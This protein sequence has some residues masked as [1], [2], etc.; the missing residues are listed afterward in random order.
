MVRGDEAGGEVM[1]ET[2]DIGRSACSGERGILGDTPYSWK[3]KTLHHGQLLGRLC[4]F[5]DSGI[6]HCV[7]SRY[8]DAIAMENDKASE[9]VPKIVPFSHS[10][11]FRVLCVG[12]PGR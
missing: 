2:S 5:S 3:L 4:L 1:D 10:D 6:R 8:I 7:I 12:D 11:S 9:N